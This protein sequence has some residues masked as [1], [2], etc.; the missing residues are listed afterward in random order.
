MK[1]KSLVRLANCVS[2][3]ALFSYASAAWSQEVQPSTAGETAGAEAPQLHDIIVTANRREESV[4]KSALAI[5]AI[6]GDTLSERNISSGLDLTQIVP[7]LVVA[8]AGPGAR[9]A[10]RGITTNNDTEV[11]N[12]DVAFNI[13]GVYLGRQRAAL[14][15]FYD[16]ERVEVLRGPQGTLYGRNAAAG[17]INIITKAPQLT[18]VE[19]SAS[20]GIG[21]YNLLETSGTINVPVS[22]TFGL[23]AAFQSARHAGYVN[24][25]PSPRD[26]D[27]QDTVSAR[28]S[29]LFKPSANFRALLVYEHSHEGGAGTGGIGGGGPL[30]LYAKNSGSGPYRW[31]SRPIT[32]FQDETI[33]SITALI[34]LNTDL[35]DISYVGNYRADDWAVSGARA[36]Q[37]PTSGSCQVAVEFPKNAAENCSNTLNKSDQWQTSHELRFSKNTDWLKAVIGL[38]YYKEH[39]AVVNLIKP[40][41]AFVDRE[42]VFDY[43]DV[44]EE[45]KAIFGQ[46]TLIVSPRLRVT[47]GA[48]YTHDNKFRQG[49]VINAPLGSTVDFICRNCVAPTSTIT[50]NLADLSW[51]KVTWKGAV[52]FDLTP[53]SLLFGSVSTGYKAGG[54]GD[55]L[56]GNNFP[57]DPETLI[58]YELGWKNSFFNRRVVINI[59]AF[60]TIFKNYQASSGAISATGIVSNVTRNAGEATID[61]VELEST[62]VVSRADRLD[63]NATWLNAR[64]TDFYLPNGDQFGPSFACGSAQVSCPYSLTGKKLTYAPN[65]TARISWEHKFELANAQTVI[66]RADSQYSAAYNVEYHGFAATRQKGYTRSGLSLTYQPNDSWSVM[67]WVRNIENKAILI[68]G[69]ADGGSPGKDFNNYGRGAFWMAPRT[70]GVKLSANF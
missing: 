11:G 59:D 54:Y 38:Y 16:V 7:N 2:A 69:D 43:P 46:A 42:F 31:F 15:A 12:P 5:T 34:D 14:T 25:A 60:H 41:P 61:G 57:Y 24:S 17:S 55:G 48:R 1:P 22:D 36:A 3:L 66:L 52:D 50:P 10:I 18:E 26:Y 70:Y 40:H 27:D 6:S 39:N 67:A 9:V 51:S 35:I 21:N 49:N 23:R 8:Q 20:L 47:G 32:P 28:V 33:D 65:F 44:R 63:F 13:N 30:G 58:N 45:S 62:F 29:A 37:G 19:G 53:T 56:P 68:K 64:F 4:Q